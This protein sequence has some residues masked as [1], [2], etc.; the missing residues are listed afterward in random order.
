MSHTLSVALHA[1][2]LQK[3]ALQQAGESLAARVQRDGQLDSRLFNCLQV[4]AMHLARVLA[5]HAAAQALLEYASGKHAG[6]FE[7]KIAVLF[8][9][10]SVINLAH[11]FR[12]GLEEFG[13][14]STKSIS[15]LF[16]CADDLQHSTTSRVWSDLGSQILQRDRDF[17]GATGLD[18]VHAELR[19][20]FA[21]FSDSVIAPVA[22][23]THRKDRLVSDDILHQLAD[24]GAFGISIPAEYGGSFLDHLVMIIA[25]EEL[26]RGSLGAGGS[27]LTRPEICAKALLA[28]GTEAQKKYWL[29][30]IASGERMVCVAVTEP[31]TGS[32]VAGVALTAEKTLGGYI[33]NGE[34]T[35]ATFAGRAEILC[36]LARTGP[37]DSGH[38][39]LSLFLV[40]KPYDRAEK[41]EYH[42]KHEQPEGGCID[43]RA[44]PTIGYRGM[45]SFSVSFDNYFV[46]AENLIGEEG[47]GFYLQM[48]G[49]AGGRI[50][51]AARAV[52]VMEA[53]FRATLGYVKSRKLFGQHL[54]DFPLTQYK[55]AQMAARIQASRQL[56]YKVAAMMDLGQGTMEAS[57]V[58]LL[59]CRDSEWVT[60]EAMQLHGGMGYSEEYPVSRYFLDA[61]V[62][63]IF[64][65]AEEVLALQV[66][67]RPYLQQFLKN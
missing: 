5:E 46:P 51:T 19:S 8:T 54:A 60:R 9:A 36:V 45:H 62:L 49:F 38:K 28:G 10:Q 17:S 61:R 14:G 47:R 33:L 35:W 20:M 44:I 42:F 18:E 31:N 41:N 12:Y 63:S 56:A 65:G 25:T 7:Q 26:S 15:A 3:E 30:L 24:L 55:L 43:G 23:E 64:E 13:L 6:D 32:D 29:P 34:K 52:G 53:S 58:K 11:Q 2:A 27:V 40:E 16:S 1:A 66:I 22:E 67:A 4:P 21:K 39:G 48:Q 37:Q 57:L 50:Q 59:A